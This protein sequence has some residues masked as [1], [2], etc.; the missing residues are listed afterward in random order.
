MDLPEVKTPVFIANNARKA[1]GFAMHILRNRKLLYEVTHGALALFVLSLLAYLYFA[2][3]DPN[4]YGHPAVE[5]NNK[6]AGNLSTS[7][8]SK[9]GVNSINN[10]SKFIVYNATP[11]IQYNA[12]CAI[13]LPQKPVVILRM[14]D[15]QAYAWAVLM[16][17]LTDTVLARNMSIVL[18][19]IPKNMEK[20]TLSA[21]YLLSKANDSRVEIALHGL[22]HS[23][24]EFLNVSA[25]QF[26]VMA[27]NGSSTLT[28]I[29]GANPVT[30][31]PPYD[32]YKLDS[33]SG[34]SKIGFRVFS[35]KQHEYKFD[36]NILYLGYTVPTKDSSHSEL[37]S[38]PGVLDKCNES[39]RYYN[40]C[41]ILI[42]P[43]DYADKAG[44]IN[45]PKYLKF[46]ELLDGIEKLG[47]TTT[48]RE[49]V[50]CK[51]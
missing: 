48:F 18:G 36:N 8:C 32:E 40:Y 45:Y 15:V 24:N 37:D 38:V 27:L 7:V 13:N 43:Q 29:F 28:S 46:A 42:H 21:N 1:M 4:L 14:D 49:F 22:E 47:A 50:T 41:V 23:E 12:S 5:C 19:V 9:I 25:P 6:P 3:F 10:N 39:L 2:N 20:N 44:G 51:Q 34:L 33:T 17:N 35:G 11:H 30:F 26:E 16:I 31:V